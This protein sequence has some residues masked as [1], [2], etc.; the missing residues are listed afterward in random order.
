[1]LLGSMGFG[2]GCSESMRNEGPARTAEAPRREITLV[3]W[4]AGIGPRAVKPAVLTIVA[5]NMAGQRVLTLRM[6]GR[7]C[8]ARREPYPTG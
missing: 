1:M 2:D 5:N 4:E 6:K 7:I 3:V 8:M